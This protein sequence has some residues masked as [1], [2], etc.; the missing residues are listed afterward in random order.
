MV[1]FT[2]LAS[3]VPIEIYKQVVNMIKSFLVSHCRLQSGSGKLAIMIDL[4]EDL[5]LFIHSL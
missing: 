4:R 1:D 3:K 5:H 2:K